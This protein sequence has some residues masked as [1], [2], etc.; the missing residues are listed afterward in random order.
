M[1]QAKQ[2]DLERHMA[3]DIKALRQ[4]MPGLEA[5]EV[6]HRF[7]ATRRWRFDFAWPLRMIAL[8]VEGGTARGGRHNKAIG[9]E[10][11]CEKYNEAARLGWKVYR[12]TSAMVKDGRAIETMRRAFS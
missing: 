2:S 4:E 11:D 1:G 9:F 3:R 5:P 10:K 7:H 12:V 6:E 8:E